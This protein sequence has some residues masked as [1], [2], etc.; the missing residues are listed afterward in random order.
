[1]AITPALRATVVG[2]IKRHT[3]SLGFIG[4]TIKVTAVRETRFG[5]SATV[6]LQQGTGQRRYRATIEGTQIRMKA[7]GPAERILAPSVPVKRSA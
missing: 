1:M 5:Y 2:I 7:T 4:H 3:R 6:V